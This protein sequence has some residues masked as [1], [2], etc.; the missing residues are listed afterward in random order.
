MEK[1][2]CFFLSIFK[3]KNIII[4]ESL[5]TY[6]D[7]AKAVYDYLI[8]KKYNEKYK[9]IWFCDQFCKVSFNTKNVRLVKVW[10]KFRKLSFFGFIKYMYYLKNA[11]YIMYCNRGIHKFN[12]K[13]IRIF[14]NH[15]LPLKRVSDLKIV[16]PRVDYVICPSEFFKN[17]Y[18]EQLHVS[19]NKILTLGSPRNDIMYNYEKKDWNFTFIKEKYNKIVLWLPTF[20]N[21]SGYDRNDSDFSFPLGFPIIYTREKLEELDDLLEDNNVLLLLKLH[22]VQD[23]SV[24]TKINLRNIKL[25]TDNDL[26]NNNISL[27]EFLYYVDAFITDYSGI[28]YDMLLTDKPIGFTIDDFDDY[29]KKRGFP[30]DNPLEKMAGM[31]IKDFDELKKY[32]NNVIN[33]KDNFK[34][35]R[36]EMRELFYDRIDADSSKRIIDY[37]KL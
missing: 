6:T 35:K 33:N 15:G 17:V 10:K 24:V 37:F 32:F 30:F 26:L 31:K 19:K 21:H 8:E 23:I 14:L 36:K 7:N 9:I 29:N 18:S 27:N 25:I 1:L 20:R 11:K 22:P 12:K 2:I 3:I 13:S 16:T 28:Y 5:P 4:F 34:N